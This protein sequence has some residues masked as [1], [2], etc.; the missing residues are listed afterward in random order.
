MRVESG[1][2]NL[3][4]VGDPRGREKLSTPAL[5]V[6]LDPFETNLALMAQ[7][8]REAGI[9]LRPHV[10]G[11]K[12]LEIARRQVASGAIGL[13]CTTLAE[14]ELMAPVAP[15]ILITSPVLGEERIARLAALAAAVPLI[16][17]VDSA[18][19]GVVAAAAAASGRSI[20]VLVDIDVGQRRTGAPAADAGAVLAAARAVSATPGLS[21]AGLQAYCGHLQG[22]VDFVERSARAREAQTAVSRLAALLRSEGLPPEIVSG[23]GTGTAIVDS[24]GAP[25]TELQPGSYPFL[26]LQYGR[27]V[28]VPDQ[29]PWF[30]QSLRVRSRVVSA[31]QADRVTIDAGMKAIAT[32]G[33]PPAIAPGAGVSGDYVFAGDE[34]G[35]LMLAAGSPRPKPGAAVEL[36]P[37]HCDT[38]TNLHV[39]IHAV[40]GPALEAVWPV[41]ARGRW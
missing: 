2:A 1:E 15:S 35:F 19:P 16:V 9:G 3:H 20:R 32:D 24:S 31:N 8:C 23:G 25:F 38:T 5:L 27:E 6:D 4:I 17:V 7:L 41:G 26:D 36:I 30:R 29:R 11:H 39:A 34:H 10:K 12:C 33:G 28:L 21:F 18:A 13:A 37:A 22:V 40:R 14:A